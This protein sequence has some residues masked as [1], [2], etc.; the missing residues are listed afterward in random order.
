[1]EKF[2]FSNKCEI[3]YKTAFAFAKYS[4]SKEAEQAIKELD[5]KEING[6]TLKIEWSKPLKRKISSSDR[7]YNC[8][9]RGHFAKNCPEKSRLRYSRYSRSR[10]RSLS[11]SL[12]NRRHS[13]Y[14][15]SRHRRDNYRRRNYSRSRSRNSREEK[16]ESIKK[17]RPRGVWN[18]RRYRERYKNSRSKSGS[19]RNEENSYSKY[20]KRK[21]S[22]SKEKN[23]S[24]RYNDDN[25]SSKNHKSEKSRN[26][27]SNGDNNKSKEEINKSIEEKSDWEIKNFKP[28]DKDQDGW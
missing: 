10:S 13:R 9:H 25:W 8:G 22:R 18:K 19:R 17:E 20:Y 21:R 5:K 3:K 4:S 1:M 7:C 14:S 16:D 26:S 28:L 23:R 2:N 15:R 27:N 12:S 24:S 6:R 11:R